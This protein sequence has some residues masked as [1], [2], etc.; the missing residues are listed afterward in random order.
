[1]PPNFAPA[2]LAAQV[3]ATPVAGV[4]GAGKLSGALR[5][6]LNVIVPSALD[7]AEICGQLDVTLAVHTRVSSVPVAVGSLLPIATRGVAGVLGLNVSI[8]RN[9]VSGFPALSVT[10][11]GRAHV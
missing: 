10:Q 4:P 11:I 8:S 9:T 5:L 6:S 2:L 7:V 1:M 3:K